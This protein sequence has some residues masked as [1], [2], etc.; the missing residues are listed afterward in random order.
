MSELLVRENEGWREGGQKVSPMLRKYSA[1]VVTGVDEAAAAFAALGISDAEAP[2]R[3][4]VIANLWGA[5]AI[6]RVLEV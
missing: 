5:P 2:Y 3:S 1:A 4:V 6:D